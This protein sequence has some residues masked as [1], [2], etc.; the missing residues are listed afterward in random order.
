M[1]VDSREENLD[2]LMSYTPLGR[3]GEPDEMGGVVAF[4]CSDDA[5]YITGE[6]IVAAG[7]MQS[8]I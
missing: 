4:L 8:R 3:V 7:G 2:V 1:L 6:V 5:S